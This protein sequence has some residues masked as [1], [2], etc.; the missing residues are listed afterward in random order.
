[1]PDLAAAPA[2]AIVEPA[3]GNPVGTDA[4]SDLKGTATQEKPKEVVA[5]QDDPYEFELE[6]KG[7][8]QKVKFA[9]KDLLKAALQKATYADS[10]IKEA[11]QKVKGTD[12]LMKKISTPQGLREVLADPAIN[13]DVK[14]FALEVVKEMM[15]DEK[16]TPEQ[17]ENRE[18]KSYREKN[19]AAIKERTEF[20]ER[21]KLEE[22]NRAFATEIRTEIIGAMKKYP[23]IPQT[24]ATMDACIMNMRAAFKRF[25]K[26]LTAEQAMTVYSQQYW[27]SLQQIID[28]MPADK[29]LERFG[30]KTLDKIQQ[31]KLNELKK[32][33]DPSQK[34][35]T[36]D[37]SIKKK[38]HLTEKEFE[39]HFQGLAGL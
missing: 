19:E 13:L 2:P 28:N 4:G 32:K 33:T 3:I 37:E 16:L 17:R 7:Q 38:K 10:I 15:D 26:H 31:I 12:A 27:T 25:G 21:Q 1:M 34:Q 9:N 39:K 6:I 8:K 20:E 18:L 36:G 24:Q 5:T 22:K 29:V 30:K 14:K 11:S 35:S 23:D